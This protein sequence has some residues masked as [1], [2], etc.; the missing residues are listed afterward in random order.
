MSSEAKD[1]SRLS[2]D[3]KLKEE[4]LEKLQKKYGFN[5]K[6]I[7]LMCISVAIR[8]ELDPLASDNPDPNWHAESSEPQYQLLKSLFD[9]KT[10]VKL[11][12]ELANAGLVF[13]NNKLSVDQ[14]LDDVTLFELH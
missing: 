1:S 14:E 4:V 2:V 5:A 3:K 12:G 13:L 11:A 6:T 7:M 9:T 8:N 10:P